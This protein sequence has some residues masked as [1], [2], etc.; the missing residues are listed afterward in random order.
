M[1]RPPHVVLTAILFTLAAPAVGFLSFGIVPA[2]LFFS[3]YFAGFVFWLFAPG[4]APLSAY[5]GAYVATF[6]LFVVHRV[7]ERLTGFFPWLAELTGVPVPNP[8]SP[9]IIILLLLSVAAWIGAPFLANRGSQFGQY[10][11][12]TFFGSMGVTE[13]AHFVLPFFT[14]DPFHYFPGMASVFLLAPAAWFG[15]WLLWRGRPL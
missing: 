8:L 12:W 13:L 3:G 5:R 7:E 11:V 6:A 14:P 9:A 2:L 4:D 1:K 10:L 15:M